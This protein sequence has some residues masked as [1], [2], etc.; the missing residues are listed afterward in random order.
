[1]NLSDE[2]GRDRAERRW[3]EEVIR[4]LCLLSDVEGP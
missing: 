1:M 2:A 3:F 4:T